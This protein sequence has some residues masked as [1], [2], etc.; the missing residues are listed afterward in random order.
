M[1]FPLRWDTWQMSP[2][3]SGGLLVSLWGP[4]TVSPSAPLALLQKQPCRPFW[5]N[6]SLGVSIWSQ[7]HPTRAFRMS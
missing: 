5:E 1:A 6:S 3:I 2:S 7:D 4:H